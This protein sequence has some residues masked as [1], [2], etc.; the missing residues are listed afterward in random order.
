LEIGSTNRAQSKGFQIALP[1]AG[2]QR[3][4]F[5]EPN[6]AGCGIAAS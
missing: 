6:P 1:F 5:S 3:F 4:G 2:I